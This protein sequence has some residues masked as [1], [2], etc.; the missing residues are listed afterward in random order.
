MQLSSLWPPSVSAAS[1]PL[2]QDSARN[3]CSA[4]EFQHAPP[5]SCKV[6]A[7]VTDLPRFDDYNTRQELHE[8]PRFS[9][10][11]TQDVPHVGA[12]RQV[13]ATVLTHRLSSPQRD[14]R[15]L[16]LH[17]AS[18]SNPIRMRS[19]TISTIS[20]PSMGSPVCSSA[21]EQDRRRSSSFWPASSSS[22]ASSLS[23]ANRESDDSLSRPAL[24]DLPRMLFPARKSL[25]DYYLSHPISTP[26][27]KSSIGSPTSALRP[28]GSPY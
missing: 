16:P 14:V 5:D 10:K 9:R 11:L 22:P 3:Y 24:P 4:T 13:P 15:S 19:A 2:R 27:R 25:G 18:P 21:P 8:L 7:P 1:V 28:R 12:Q 26:R 20:R 23:D 17:D 6:L